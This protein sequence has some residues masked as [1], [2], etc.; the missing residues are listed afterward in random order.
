MATD[1]PELPPTTDPNPVPDT[2][3]VDQ[4]LAEA[5]A[6]INGDPYDRSR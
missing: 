4:A 3:D 2:V 6:A 5:D 1:A